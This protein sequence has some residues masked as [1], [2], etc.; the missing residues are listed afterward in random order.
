MEDLFD[1]TDCQL[2][3]TCG[4]TVPRK[5]PDD[6][7]VTINECSQADGPARSTAVTCIAS[8]VSP[9]NGIMTLSMS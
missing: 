5:R 3:A 1:L 8:T 4:N 6:A 9:K 7:Y 2:T